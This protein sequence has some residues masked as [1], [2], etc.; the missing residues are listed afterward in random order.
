M[1]LKIKANSFATQR[2][3]ELDAGGITFCETAFIGG[4]RRFRFD[5]VELVLMSKDNNLSFQVGQEVFQLPVNP[6]NKKHEAVINA[7][8]QGVSQTT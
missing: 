4:R 1:K 6:K 3:L 2:Y 5:Q 7:L 8:L